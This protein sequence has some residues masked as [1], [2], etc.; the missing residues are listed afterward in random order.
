MG[1]WRTHYFISQRAFESDA[2]TEVFD[3][4][5]RGMLS[6]L[7]IELMATSGS[8][9]SDLYMADILS[10]IEIIGNGSTVIK[11]YD[12]RQCQAIMAFDDGFLPPDKEYSPSGDCWGYFDIRFGRFLGDEKYALN[13]GDWQSL[14][15]KLTY[16]L[17]AGGTKGTTG[18]TT[19]TGQ[20]TVW[21]LYAPVEAGFTPVGYIKSEEKKVYTTSAAGTEDLD[22]PTDYPYRRLLLFTETHGKYPNEA[23]RYTTINVNEGA[24]KPVDRLE[25]DDFIHW[26]ALLLK[27]GTFMHTKRYYMD[28]TQTNY[29]HSPLRYMRAAHIQR[30]YACGF[31]MLSVFDPN[32]CGIDSEAAT[33]S[34]FYHMTVWGVCPWGALVFDLEKQSGGLDGRPAMEAVWGANE[35]DDIDLEFEA[36]TADIAVS[37]LLEQYARR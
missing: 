35:S 7:L 33:G 18:F 19:A 25:G 3:L 29:I 31:H 26:Q 9:N 13:C 16:D 27:H 4:P 28:N 14:E 32:V 11:S 10:K 5:S 2:Q 17:A 8:E 24:R 20:F 1:F 6:N 34:G 15:L 22:L 23:F 37:I 12:G 30:Q 36:L 21:G